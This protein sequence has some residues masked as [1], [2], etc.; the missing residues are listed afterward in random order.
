MLDVNF[1]VIFKHCAKG[2]K[3]RITKKALQLAN[4]VNWAKWAIYGIY[5]VI[6]QVPKIFSQLLTIHAKV[7][8]DFSVPVVFAFLPDKLK[9]T[10]QKV[11][12]QLKKLVPLLD[13]GGF[14]KTFCCD[15]ERGLIGNA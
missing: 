12:R 1:S 5:N 9:A 13:T 11:F 2:V 8:E 14:L 3:I 4:I 7:G 10:Y 6:F 15:F